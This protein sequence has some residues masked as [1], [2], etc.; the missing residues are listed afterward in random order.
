MQDLIIMLEWKIKM[1]TNYKIL[2]G[3]K[4]SQLQDGLVLKNEAQ[5]S[6]LDYSEFRDRF[7]T[8]EKIREEKYR[9]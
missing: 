8:W 5:E 4:V 7:K 3:E 9:C 1:E 2:K 6:S